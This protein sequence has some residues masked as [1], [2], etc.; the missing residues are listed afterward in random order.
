MT[1]YGFTSINGDF[2]FARNAKSALVD[3]YLFED[4]IW[5][6]KY[7]VDAGILINPEFDLYSLHIHKATHQ[8]LFNNDLDL[9]QN[10]VY[11]L[12]TSPVGYLM[13]W[14][15]SYLVANASKIEL[16]GDSM[17]QKLKK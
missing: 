17:R 4:A 14:G 8:N 2:V 10:Q 3:N 16:K 11:K 5:Q 13:P 9:M 12:L 1:K 15:G 7:A 6:R